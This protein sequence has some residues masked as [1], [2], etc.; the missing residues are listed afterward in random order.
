MGLC[1]ATWQ[2][3]PPF[4]AGGSRLFG[5]LGA[6]GWGLGDRG[7]RAAGAE[8]RAELGSVKERPGLG[9]GGLWRDSL[10]GCGNMSSQAWVIWQ[11]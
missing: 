4:W 10:W 7:A 9:Q 3:C 2:G 11:H 5:G 1:V 8:G 6:L